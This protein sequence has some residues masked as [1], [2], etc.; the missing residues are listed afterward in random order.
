MRIFPMTVLLSL[1]AAP[2][3]AMPDMM[4]ATPKMR[5]LFGFNL[6][7]V[8]LIVFC[9]G[10]MLSAWIDRRRMQRQT[11]HVPIKTDRK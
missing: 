1:I 9:L 7:V 6:V 2:A 3:M 8:A 5:L 10:V 11:V 4:L